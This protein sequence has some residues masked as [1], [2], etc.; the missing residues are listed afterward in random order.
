[1]SRLKI[2]RRDFLNG[3]A[4][5]VATGGSLSPLEILA[6]DS[7]YPPALTGL[8]G[9]HPGSFEI[10]HALSWNH[11]RWPQPG[12]LTDGVYDLVVVGGGLS[13]LAAAFLYR[14]QAGADAKVLVLDNH[15]DFGGHAKRNEFDVDG[16][17]LIGYGGSQSIDS[18]GR[19]SAASKQI[20][21]DVGVVTQR[22]YDHFDRDFYSARGLERGIYFSSDRYGADSVHRNALRF[23]G[24]TDARTFSAAISGYPIPAA[25]RQSLVELAT[26]NVDVFASL[27]NE[28]KIDRLRG[29]S[30]TDYLAK[31]VGVHEDAILLLRDPVRGWWGVGYDAVSALE[32]WRLGMPG[33]H[34]VVDPEGATGPAGREEPYIFHFP[35]GNAGVARSLVRA[36]LPAAV[37][38]ETMEDLVSSR[39]DYG[40]LDL[41]ENDVRIRLDSTAVD[42]RHADGKKAV[43]VTYVRDGT[44]YRVRGRHA[45]LACYNRIV[46]HLCS[47]LP[48]AQVEAINS[49]VKVP[50]VYINVA[51]RSW[52]AFA[53][54]GVH[55]LYIPQ[56]VR[57]HSL[58][59]DFPV[60]MGDYAFTKRPEE[61]TV[62][63]GAYVP[64]A[65]GSGLSAR[66]QHVK[67]RREL[68]ELTF[69][70]FE[71]HI[72][73]VL[74]GAL[75]RGGFDVERD[76]AAITVNRWPHGYAYEYNDLYDPPDWGPTKGP[77]LAGAAQLGRISIANSDAS[78]YAFVNG[79]FD[80]A[81][82]AVGEQLEVS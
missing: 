7:R 21:S 62:L 12:E 50:L 37:P 54:L 5:G 20:L 18:P 70:D 6:R 38:G 45:I 22:F 44:P 2:S 73:S 76:L 75:G 25:A 52:Q 40:S 48:A 43:D 80:A 64:C 49:A 28:E 41:E 30:Y 68:Y 78:A 39:V 33:V 23:Y 58:G 17:R 74:D 11:V 67:G 26:G 29:M 19:Y 9:S 32:A 55:D 4:L 46:P 14:Q 42:V 72:V 16:R 8:R 59:M 27:S 65:P 60:S 10:A 15:D 51:V 81:A 36:L 57:M 13:G 35:D 69:D 61:P 47:E 63:H 79:A 53:N 82:R 56:P 31:H 66:E 34:G 24:E 71:D 77:H 1:M 3:L